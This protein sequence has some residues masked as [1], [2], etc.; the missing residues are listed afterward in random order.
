MKVLFGIKIS[1]TPNV[2]LLFFFFF[3]T[4]TRSRQTTCSPPRVDSCHS[5]SPSSFQPPKL[6]QVPVEFNLKP[7][8]PPHLSL[9]C[10]TYPVCLR[11][12]RLGANFLLFVAAATAITTPGAAAPL[13]PP[14]THHHW[15]PQEH[16]RF[17]DCA[18]APRGVC[19]GS[20]APAA[21]WSRRP[22]T[23]R[24]QPPDSD[25][26]TKLLKGDLILHASFDR[27]FL[28]PKFK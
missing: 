13:L 1:A 9:F 3:F 11:L 18:A 10:Y 4:R 25:S 8:N 17:A 6:N 2:P 7:I 20:F 28:N 27:G 19:H 23:R 24:K 26:S 5:T 21:C 14:L 22:R 16:Q 12:G 15:L